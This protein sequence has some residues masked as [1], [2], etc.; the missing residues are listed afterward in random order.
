MKS[1]DAQGAGSISYAA[2][3]QERAMARV[4]LAIYWEESTGPRPLRMPDL[5]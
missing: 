2:S 3:G 4:P 1:Q 5:F